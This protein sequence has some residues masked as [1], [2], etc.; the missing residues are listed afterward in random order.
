MNNADSDTDQVLNVKGLNL[1]FGGLKALD[2]V[3]FQVIDRELLAIIGPNGAGKTTIFNCLTGYYQPSV[4]RLTLHHPKG[5][6]LLERID[7]V[8]L[9]STEETPGETALNAREHQGPR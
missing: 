3:D 5:E 7:S 8:E 9:E 6:F 4:G 1:S 2:G